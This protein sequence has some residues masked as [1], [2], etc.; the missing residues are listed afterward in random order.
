MNEVLS[1]FAHPAT[2]FELWSQDIAPEKTQN[3]GSLTASLWP[4]NLLGAMYLQF[5]WLIT[6]AGDLSRCKHCG[7]FLSYAPPISA[8]G[9]TRKPR[10]D[11]E[12]CDSRCRQNYHYHARLKP[13]RQGKEKT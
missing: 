8:T 4:R 3:L 2:T 7:R 10:N 12:F 6:S 11:K 9:K 13:A 1:A 5:Y